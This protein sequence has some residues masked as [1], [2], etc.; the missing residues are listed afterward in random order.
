MHTHAR[1]HTHTHTYTHT[2][3]YYVIHQAWGNLVLL[4][5]TTWVDNNN[6]GMSGCGN[7]IIMLET[8]VNA[9]EISILYTVYVCVCVCWLRQLP[10]ILCNYTNLSL[11]K[12]APPGVIH[13]VVE[14]TSLIV[15]LLRC[16]SFEYR[17]LFSCLLQDQGIMAT[18]VNVWS[19][20]HTF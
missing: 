1:T 16:I 11:W 19:C 10:L 20:L 12:N 8:C 2:L 9:S 3:D 17:Y 7:Y 14:F 13:A 15:R 6:W 4:V 5:Y 18:V